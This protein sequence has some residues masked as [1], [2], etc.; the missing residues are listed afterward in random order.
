MRICGGCQSEVADKVENCPRCGNP[1]P[2]GFLSSLFGLFRGKAEPPVPAPSPTPTRTRDAAGRF[3]FRVEDVFSISGRGTVVTGRVASGE[4]RV[5]DE[6]AFTSPKGKA[7][8]CAVIGVEMFRKVL[9]VAKA[10]DTVGL[11]LRGVKREDIATGT[12][13]EAV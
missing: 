6:V 11:L 5:G 3:A 7:M 2:R 1:M 10:G 8:T 12:D 13:L 9:D 4:I